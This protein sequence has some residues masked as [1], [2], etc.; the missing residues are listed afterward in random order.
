MPKR[1]PN[2]RV[3]YLVDYFDYNVFGISLV[4][5]LSAPHHSSDTIRESHKHNLFSSSFLFFPTFHYFF[6]FYSFCC[7]SSILAF[8]WHR[9]GSE[10]AT[11]SPVL[12]GYVMNYLAAFFGRVM[13][14]AVQKQLVNFLVSCVRRSGLRCSGIHG[15]MSRTC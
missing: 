15:W 2:K 5:A 1:G 10:A 12:A 7:T 11:Q 9:S 14:S 3:T 8:I 4:N 13:P 6:V